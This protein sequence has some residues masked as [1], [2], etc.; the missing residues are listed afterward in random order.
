MGEDKRFL[1]AILFLIFLCFPLLPQVPT[2]DPFYYELLREGKFAFNSGN[3]KEAV[4]DFKIAAFGF[5]D[6]RA[7]LTECYVYLLICFYNLKDI[8]SAKFYDDEIKNLGGSD[9]LK[10]ANLPKDIEAKFLEI[11]H[12]LSRFSSI[13][14]VSPPKDD[15]IKVLQ[16]A[17]NKDP[18]DI[19]NYYKLSSVYIDSLKFK[20]AVEIWENF[21]KIDKANPYPYIE[22]GKIYR[23]TKDYKKAL[24]YLEK[25]S[26]LLKTP[27]PELH[28]ELGVVYFEL[29][30]YDKA[31]EELSIVRKIN[32]NFKELPAYWKALD[33]IFGKRRNE[34]ES[35]LKKALEEKNNRR[36]IEILK[37]A[38]EMN[39]FNRKIVVEF[40]NSLVSEKKEEEAI[41]VIDDFLTQL[42]QFKM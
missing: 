14:K 26:P 7:K 36:K 2:E 17:I 42:S 13:P 40:A 10:E 12:Y 35:L 1:S 39:P 6:N 32:E 22:I 8:E 24:Q 29:G 15:E 20:E 9:V 21:L 11:S 31:Y 41:K 18:K 5:I 16:E 27:E 19:K 33:E 30:S 23:L 34:A 28:Y 3:Y 37:K 25:A 4:E 38:K